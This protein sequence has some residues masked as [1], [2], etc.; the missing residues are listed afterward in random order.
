M[1]SYAL[2][3]AAEGLPVFPLQPGGKRPFPGTRGHNEATTDPDLIRT[4]WNICQNA[5]IG[6]AVPDGWCVVDVDP[7][8]HGD[9]TLAALEAEHGPL[10]LTRLARTGGGGYHAYFLLPLGRDL[11]GT[12]GAGVD[13]QKLGK[14]V[15][16]PPSIHESGRPYEWI[17]N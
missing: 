10:P 8:N 16:A 12:L 13:V 17:S 1:L 11:P 6:I 7:R 2:A 4:W 9:K 15:V 14:Y 3:Y 5:N